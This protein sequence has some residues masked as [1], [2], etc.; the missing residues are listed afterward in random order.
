MYWYWCCNL[1][2][3]VPYMSHRLYYTLYLVQCSSIAIRVGDRMYAAYQH[4]A[5]STTLKMK[6]VRNSSDFRTTRIGKITS[7]VLLVQQCCSVQHQY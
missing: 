7:E 2:V 5:C 6:R 3:V 4:A 1:V